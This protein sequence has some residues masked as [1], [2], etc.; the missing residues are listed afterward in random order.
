MP[1]DYVEESYLYFLVKEEHRD[2]IRCKIDGL[3]AQFKAAQ[4]GTGHKKFI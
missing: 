3:L 1:Q 4:Q 2:F